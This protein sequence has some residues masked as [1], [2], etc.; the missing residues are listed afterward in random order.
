MPPSLAPARFAALDFVQSVVEVDSAF[1]KPVLLVA[2]KV[3]A[4]IY[5]TL[6]SISSSVAPYAASLLRK[7]I[8]TLISKLFGLVR[9]TGIAAVFGVGAVADAY[10]YAYIIPGFLLVL[11]GG[12][13]SRFTVP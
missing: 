1:V 10:N 7:A 12:I 13:N 2:F 3:E 9:S 8:A 11:L 4:C 6:V 5:G